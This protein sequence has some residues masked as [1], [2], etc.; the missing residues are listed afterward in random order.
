[1]NVGIRN[2]NWLSPGLKVSVKML[3][4]PWPSPPPHPLHPLVTEMLICPP[5]NIWVPRSLHWRVQHGTGGPAEVAGPVLE[6]P[7]HQTPVRPPQGLLCLRIG[8]EPPPRAKQPPSA[9]PIRPTLSTCSQLQGHIPP[10]V[11]DPDVPLGTPGCKVV[12]DCCLL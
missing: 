10:V 5:Q 4:L 2:H 6:R 8:P 3:H 9:K 11:H 12:H 7:G 1:M